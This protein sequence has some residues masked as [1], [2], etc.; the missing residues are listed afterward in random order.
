VSSFTSENL[1]GLSSR[2]AAVPAHLPG[3]LLT[4]EDFQTSVGQRNFDSLRRFRS[5]VPDRERIS[6][7]GSLEWAPG[8]DAV[9]FAEFL[10]S[11]GRTQMHE[12]PFT[13][14]NVIVP[15]NNPFNPFGIPVAASFLPA[16]GPRE[17]TTDNTLLRSL[18]G[19]QGRWSRW[20]FELAALYTKDMTRIEQDNVLM[21][22]RVSA[23]LAQTDPALAL[24]VFDDGPG[25]SASLL[26]SLV[27]D[28][29]VWHA[30]SQ[31]I[32]GTA[33]AQG[34][35]WRLPAG[36]LSGHVGAEWRRSAIFAEPQFLGS[37]ARTVKAAFLELGVPLINAEMKVPAISQLALSV[38][39]RIDDF[40]DIGSIENSQF[41]LVWHPVN[42]LSARAAY[43]TTYRPPTLFDLN[44]PPLH[45]SGAL[46]DLRRN[47]EIT[48]IVATVGGNPDLTPTRAHSWSLGVFYERRDAIDFDASA[49]Y[50]RTDL[51]DR[52]SPFTLAT[53]LLH[54][55]MFPGRVT[56]AAPTPADLAAGLPGV[57]TALDTS[58]VNVGTL[59][60]SGIDGAIS[61]AFNTRMGRIASSLS[62]TWMD[63]FTV[64]DFPGIAPNERVGIA[65]FFGTIPEWY[66]IGTLDWSGKAWSATT[67]AR[68]VS[69][70][71]DLSVFTDRP[72]GRRVPSQLIVDVQASLLFNPYVEAGSPWLDLR[73]SAG[74][75]NLFDKHAAF[76]EVGTDSGY[77]L[78]Q[79]DL[80]GR[81]GYIRLTKAF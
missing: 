27:G 16:L 34:T 72:N 58:P 73:I 39:G 1:P 30:S 43:G 53:L 74:V 19:L 60:A 26:R 36:D 32:Q 17:W 77:D 64:M 49:S 69:S 50:W 33:R 8:S 57:L 12:I 6:A 55:D 70:Y 81:F 24:N 3:E 23:A 47:N 42:G 9:A 11:D 78:T 18:A 44:R 41:A 28:P 46:P 68:F 51:Q 61:A 75:T 56:R 37:Q 54:A 59:R 40:S 31:L 76:A 52:V 35:L 21:P 66:A 13:L 38:A 15:A 22:E 62:S 29:I 67:M 14:I 20:N 7:V 79:G 65:S 4:I 10:Y 63:R 25:G 71:S 48:N 45:V 5:L 2:F 80:K